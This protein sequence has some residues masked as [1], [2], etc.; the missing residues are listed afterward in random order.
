MK[1]GFLCQIHRSMCNLY[2]KRLEAKK[3][4]VGPKGLESPCIVRSSGSYCVKV[5]FSCN[6]FDIYQNN[7]FSNYPTMQLAKFGLY[8][9]FWFLAGACGFGLFPLDEHHRTL[10]VWDQSIQNV[11]ARQFLVLPAA[12]SKLKAFRSEVRANQPRQ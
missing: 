3:K 1:L 4:K 2:K 10:V 5:R 7:S 9:I 11:W 12:R 8:I 6:N